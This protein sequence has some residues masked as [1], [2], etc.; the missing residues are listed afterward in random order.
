LVYAN[1]EAL[2]RAWFVDTVRVQSDKRTML[3]QMRD[4]AFNPRTT[5]LVESGF[6][7]MQAIGSDSASSARV[8]GSGNQKLT[9]RTT[10]SAKQMLVVSEVYYD[11][12]HAYVDGAE[13]PMVK[14]NFLLR[15]V[16]V[17]PGTHTVEFR[18]Q[19][20]AFETGR[21]ISLA[22]NIVT[23]LLGLGALGM[24]VLQRQKGQ[25]QA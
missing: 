20:P 19:S 8:V 23:T 16:V 2:P 14:T 4:G 1:E 18:Y 12:W 9:I 7:G 5:A 24:W 11:E 15:G 3:E 13:V 17:P 22:S 25:P 6:D 21:T 10:T